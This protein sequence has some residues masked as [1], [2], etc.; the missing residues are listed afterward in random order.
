M[1][2]DSYWSWDGDSLDDAAGKSSL[3]SFSAKSVETEP[4]CVYLPTITHTLDDFSR[5]KNN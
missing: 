4:E 2:W 5:L 3:P 1:G